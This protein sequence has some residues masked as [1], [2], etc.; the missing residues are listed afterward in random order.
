MKSKKE[1]GAEIKSEEAHRL[2]E[3]S[4]IDFFDFGLW[5]YYPELTDWAAENLINHNAAWFFMGKL[6]S[7]S[8][9][10]I[11]KNWREKAVKKLIY[12][13][14]HRYFG[15][16]LY[17]DEDLKPY[18][19][20]AADNL[21]EEDPYNFFYY[22]VYRLFPDIGRGIIKYFAKNY[23]DEY[24]K[25]ELDSDPEVKKL[26]STNAKEELYALL[27]KM[28]DRY[29]SEDNEILASKVDEAIL[30]LGRKKTPIK[31][32]DEGV[33]KNLINFLAKANKN[34]TNSIKGLE[35]FFR[36][37]R[38]F[39]IT[40][41]IKELGL[42][43]TVKELNK[44]EK[45]ID[46]ALKLFGEMACGKKLSKDEI[47]SIMGVEDD[48]GDALSFFKKH[49]EKDEDEIEA[50]KAKEAKEIEI[51]EEDEKDED[52]CDDEIAAFW[53]D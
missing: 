17:L 43:K 41:D 25:L 46:S 22:R 29:D 36:R 53:K 34:T 19:E 38:Y 40:E 28:A 49:E 42:D 44:I 6:D 2:A 12:Q 48:C 21:A 3:K 39:G 11:L 10:P 26:M 52:L 30:S 31:D 18:A 33:K 27:V 47:K 7:P 8:K 24:K 9:L 37:L 23:P 4:P 32:L 45:A 5:H 51:E 13:Q 14:P 20:L 16:E 35:E 1:L 50:E 15:F